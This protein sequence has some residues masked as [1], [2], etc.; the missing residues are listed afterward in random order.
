MQF[1]TGAGCGR[2]PLSLTKLHVK[3]A[4]LPPDDQV[5]AS[6]SL[7]RSR[8]GPEGENGY[9]GGP[10]EHAAG[11]GPPGLVRQL[12]VERPKRWARAD[13]WGLAALAGVLAL[14]ALLYLWELGDWGWGY[15]YYSA[16][17]QA[18]SRSL[19]AAVFGSLD[20]NGV[21][22]IDKGP[23][24]LWPSELAVRLF[25][26]SPWSVLVPYALE[27]VG[28]VALL[29]ATVARVA[30]RWAGLVA[31]LVMAVTPV[32]VASFRF[33]NPDALLT[34]LSV[35]AMYAALRSRA[36]ESKRWAWSAGVLLGMGFLAK[37]LA[38]GVVVPAVL[39]VLLKGRRSWAERASWG[40][41][42][43]AGAVTSCGWWLA[44]VWL[45]PPGS[46][47]FVGSTQD[48]SIWSLV[49][50]YDGF[51]RLT[52]AGFT[53]GAGPVWRVLWASALRLFD[54]EMGAQV[55]WLVPAAVLLVAGALAL[56]GQVA[57][58]AERTG[59]WAWGTWLAVGGLV[60]SSGQGLINAYYT[61][62]LAPAVAAA[63]AVGGGVLVR[64]WRNRAVRWWG[65]CTAAVSG[66]WAFDLLERERG[67][68]PWVRYLVLFCALVAPAL[69]VAGDLRRRAPRVALV[70]AVAL[71]GLAGP[72][73]Y[74]AGTAMA[75]VPSADPM[76]VLPGLAPGV[77]LGPRRG[78]V[79]EVS[80]PTAALVRALRAE[81][82]SREWAVAVVGGDPAAGYQLASGRAAMAVG[83]WRGTDPVPTLRRFE[84]LVV[85]GK[86]GYF[87]PATPVAGVYVPKSLAR[88]QAGRITTWVASH[89]AEV[90][91]GGEQ[92]Y[93]L[94]MPA[95]S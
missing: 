66:I 31:A 16:A 93:D 46:R 18:G 3:R 75:P 63:V 84:A 57:T 90:T 23:A 86:V 13:G 5:M 7:V 19:G 37:L 53:G 33:N 17:V 44:L 9:L 22:S 59:M 10:L 1:T 12:V 85:A 30:G 38:V 40:A 6:L 91:I 77:Q 78:G 92:L 52:G 89:F 35:G 45:V 73:S 25:G 62:L 71:T 27:G 54:G 32:A 42:A 51:N 61:V 49:F 34:L 39:V 68:Q 58:G 81:A 43:A 64:Q 95:R 36:S 48:N 74:A 26:L 21:V 88:T 8:A 65:G 56:A 60:F 94:S 14:S 55:A 76:A 79:T 41:R 69:L 4:A 87:M 11:S 67:W 15:G 83:G 29:Y 80:R 82:P 70:V 28:T 20:P 50:G 2:R 24:S 72:V 47:P